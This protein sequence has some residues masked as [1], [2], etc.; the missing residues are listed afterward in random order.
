M[1]TLPGIKYFTK[2][3]IF[4]PLICFY[5]FQIMKLSISRTTE[6]SLSAGKEMWL[7]CRCLASIM[8]MLIWI[9]HAKMLKSAD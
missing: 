5:Q 7:I 1:I 8:F 9:K 6:K 3:V 2:K 4:T